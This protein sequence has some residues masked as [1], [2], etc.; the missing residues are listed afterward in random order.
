[1]HLRRD[2]TVS[3]ERPIGAGG[4]RDVDMADVIENPD[5]VRGRLLERL[6]AGDRGDPN[7]GLPSARRSAI[8]S[9]WPG[10]QSRMMSVTRS[11]YA[12]TRLQR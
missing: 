3:H 6:I 5:G 12:P 2:V 1:V 4:D 7:S 8:A 9:S 11:G 10:S